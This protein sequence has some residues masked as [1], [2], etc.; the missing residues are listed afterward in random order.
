MTA[1]ALADTRIHPIAAFR[2]MRNLTRDK[3]DTRQVFLLNS[4]LRGKTTERQFERFR[5]SETGK[6]VLAERRKLLDRLNDRAALAALPAGTL[7]RA[8]YDFMSAEN[9][10][11]AG[12]VEAPNFDE[13]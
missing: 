7:G 2:A 4:A 10:S 3:E 6:A 5:Q 1:S 11:A 9:L 13:D 12:L 8:Y